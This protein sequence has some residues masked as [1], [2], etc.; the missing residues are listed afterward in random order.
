MSTSFLVAIPAIIQQ[1]IA[2]AE[3]PIRAATFEALSPTTA[4]I[5]LTTE[6]NTPVGISAGLD[7]FTL[8]LFLPENGTTS[9]T[10]TTTNN[11]NTQPAFATLH[12]PAHQLRGPTRLSVPPQPAQILDATSLRLLLS[13]AFASDRTTVGIRGSSTARLGRHLVYP[14]TLNKQVSLA[15]LRGLDG[16][17]VESIEPVV[18]SSAG[19]SNGSALGGSLFV[20]NWSALSLGLGNMTCDVVANGIVVGQTTVEDLR[21]VPGNQSVAYVSRLDADA[22]TSRARE[23]LGALDQEGDLDLLIRGNSS[24]VDGQRVEYLDD[25]MSQISISTQLP[26]CMAMKALPLEAMAKIPPDALL[27]IPV[28]ELL[29]C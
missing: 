5:G 4:L 19:G 28:E 20:P 7:A 22:V 16:A 11:N 21:L 17:R 8:E 10:S 2:S 15:G 24:S 26:L 13:R 25:V 14:V 12:V 1:T 18:A 23:V 3:L 9:N 27:L 29:E 6:L